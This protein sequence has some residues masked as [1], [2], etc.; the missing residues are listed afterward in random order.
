[1]TTQPSE[2]KVSRG[3]P[4]D[5]VEQPDTEVQPGEIKHGGTGDVD[6]ALQFL[7]AAAIEYT[8]E[9]SRTVLSKI[10]RVLMPLLCWVYLIQFAD[11]TS[12]N[13]ASLM[14]IRE[15]THLDPNSQQYSWVSSIF[16]A[17][18]IFWEYV[19]WHAFLRKY[20]SF[21]ILIW[22][23]VLLCHVATNSYAGLL[24]V[25]F[26]LGA[27]EATVTPAF[28]LFTSCWYKQDE[29]AKRMGFW[30]ACNGFAQILIAAIAYGLSGVQT[31]SIAVWKILFLVL[32]LPTILT[33][34]L[35][36]WFIPDDQIHARFLSHREKLIAVDRI[37]GNFQGI[38][39]HTWKW[40]H[41]FEAFRDSRTYLYVLFSLLM[42]IPNGGITTFGS[43]VIS[44]FGFSS[45]MSLLLNMPM[46]L[47]DIVCKLGLTYLSD[48]FLDRTI[49]AIIAIL[50]PMVGG[51]LMIVLPL[52]A[53][54][55]LLMGY[56]FIGAA[57]TSW[58]LVMVMISN[59]TLGYTKKATVNGLQILAYAAG[60]WIGPQT[61]RSNQAPEYFDGKMM[62]AIMYALAAATLLAIRL[63]N[64]LEN[65]RR[66]RQALSNPDDGESV[67]V[68]TEFLDLTDFEQPAFRYVL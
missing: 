55:G 10:D 64:I 38:G 32:G 8:P 35:Y 29:Q 61:F 24:C 12:L 41:F 37:R 60:N 54:A 4:N 46:G 33:G 67:V 66:D 3:P 58:C 22:G 25:R 13:Y 27:F 11:K 7:A 53:K 47:V 18:Y 51:I 5:D 49:F 28:V 9:E 21:N 39:S 34:A 2:K 57:G 26:F 20:T 36:F 15:H 63:V 23:V 59:N 19:P 65:K 16:Y 31:A 48:R 62:V 68:G 43:L 44:S 30:L 1:M 40:A 45:R 6:P 56:Y 42:N 17:G 50:I 52:H 14:G